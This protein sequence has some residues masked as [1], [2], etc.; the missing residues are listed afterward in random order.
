MLKRV[1]RKWNP[2]SLLVG[3]H[4]SWGTLEFSVENSQKLKV[5]LPYDPATLLLG[6]WPK[7]S[8]S[9][10][11]DVC[12]AM[13]NTALFPIARECKPPHFLQQVKGYWKSGAYTLWNT[14]CLAILKKNE[15]TNFASKWI[16]H[17]KVVLGEV[18]QTQNYKRCML[19]LIRGS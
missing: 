5:H 14:Y 9:S 6:M 10:S 3:L 18:T 8:T 11:T 19:S 12:S 4:T 17:G 2:Q 15:I 16:E 7:N 1:W 13:F